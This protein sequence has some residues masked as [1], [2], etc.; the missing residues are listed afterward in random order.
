M[1]EDTNGY[2]ESLL[3]VA[4]H[5]LACLSN[6]MTSAR[7]RPKA[8]DSCWQRKIRC[9]EQSGRCHGSHLV[10]GNGE[11]IRPPRKSRNASRKRPTY[12]GSPEPGNGFTRMTQ[13]VASPS[14]DR[15]T[16]HNVSNEPGQH[17]LLGSNVQVG[18]GS[19][20]TDPS[21]G[22]QSLTSRDSMTATGVEGVVLIETNEDPQK[23]KYVGKTSTQVLAKSAEEY[24]RPDGFFLGVMEF[25]CPLLSHSEEVIMTPRP[26]H[27]PL[28]NKETAISCI[29]GNVFR[30]LRP[31]FLDDKQ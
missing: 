6:A 17:L 16:I 9:D 25:F 12:L 29:N 3:P 7:R 21:P 24:F 20:S 4:D 27:Q 30:W 14:L 11:P 15:E 2:N 26:K 18:H 13:I 28:V 19:P 23:C 22:M 1:T 10:R 31:G 5:S 8:C